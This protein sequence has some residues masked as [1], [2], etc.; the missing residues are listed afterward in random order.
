ML[1]TLCVVF[2]S[3]ANDSLP[4]LAQRE[5]FPMSALQFSF[6]LVGS[7]P[8]RAMCPL[9]H[10]RRRHVDISALCRPLRW[11]TML[12]DRPSAWI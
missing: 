12:Q 4:E 7:C 1:L 5:A 3:A 6:P 2:T 11:P 8:A 10:E 9:L